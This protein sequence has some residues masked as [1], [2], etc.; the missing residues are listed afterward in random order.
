MWIKS[1]ARTFWSLYAVVLLGVCLTMFGVT[2][3]QP[4]AADAGAVAAV[5]AEASAVPAEQAGEEIASGW[6]DMLFEYWQLITSI[7]GTCA[8]IAALTPSKR[9]DRW[10]GVLTRLVDTLG[11]NVFNA[12]NRN[13]RE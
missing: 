8:L 10:M 1:W 5:Q 9:D 6:L 13:Q 12:R 4:V 2:V 11:A 3:P 7:V